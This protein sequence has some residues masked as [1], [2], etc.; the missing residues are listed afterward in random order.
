MRRT[1]VTHYMNKRNFNKH[2]EVHNDGYYH[3][4]VR[5]SMEWTVNGKR[6]INKTGDGNLHRWRKADLV[7][8]LKDYIRV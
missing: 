4:T 6:V 5:Q 8:L 7:A 1:T 2:L 3:Y